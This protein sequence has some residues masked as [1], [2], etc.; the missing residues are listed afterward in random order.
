MAEHYVDR[1]NVGVGALKNVPTAMEQQSMK[2]L[3]VG[4][5]GLGVITLLFARLTKKLNP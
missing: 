2:T 1:S 5:L 4:C 3:P